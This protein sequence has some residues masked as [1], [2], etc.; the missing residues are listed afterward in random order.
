MRIAIFSDIHANIPAL[1]AVLADIGSRHPDAAYCLGDLVGYSPFQT[2]S[3]SA[4][5]AKAFQRSW[6][7]MTTGWA[8]TGMIAGVPTARRRRNAAAISP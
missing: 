5:V 1:E 7:T 2:K 3:S 6:A 8:S 4:F